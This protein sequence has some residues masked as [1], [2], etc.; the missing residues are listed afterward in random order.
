MLAVLLLL[1]FIV[2]DATAIPKGLI[3]L[4]NSSSCPK[5]YWTDATIANG[6]F[7]VGT[8]TSADIGTLFGA[9]L[10]DR[11]D[12]IHRHLLLSVIETALRGHKYRDTVISLTEDVWISGIV[13]PTTSGYPFLQLRM[14][15]HTKDTEG[16]EGLPNGTIAFFDETTTRCPRGWEVYEPLLGRTA[17]PT[18]QGDG[19]YQG[20][21]QEPPWAPT[22]ASNASNSSAIFDVEGHRHNVV[23]QFSS[24]QTGHV[25]EDL[26]NV[27][28]LSFPDSSH[29][30]KFLSRGPDA[31]LPFVRLLPCVQV[32]P[33]ARLYGI[34]IGM[35]M[36]HKA[37]GCDQ[38]DG[39][40]EYS[41]S[42]IPPS[43][44]HRLVVGT[45]SGTV[46]ATFGS[47]TLLLPTTVVMHN[48][49][50]WANSSARYQGTQ[51]LICG[52]GVVDD[53]LQPDLSFVA[54]P[55]S[56][57]FGVPY[58]V[59]VMCQYHRNNTA[60]NAH[61]A[62]RTVLPT[63]TASNFVTTSETG[64][65]T[66]TLTTSISPTLSSTEVGTRTAAL[67]FTVTSEMTA[68]HN[69]MEDPPIILRNSSTFIA[70]AGKSVIKP[71]AWRRNAYRLRMVVQCRQCADNAILLGSEVP[72]QQ[73][74]DEV[75]VTI[76]NATSNG[77]CLLLALEGPLTYILESFP[78]AGTKQPLAVTLYSTENTTFF[79]E[80]IMYFA[81]TYNRSVAILSL[82]EREV[83]GTNYTEVRGVWIANGTSQPTQE[84]VTSLANIGIIP[85][86]QAEARCQKKSN[87][88]MV[89][90]GLFVGL[91]LIAVLIGGGFAAYRY[92]WAQRQKVQ[93]QQA[94]NTEHPSDGSSHAA[95]GGAVGTSRSEPL[96]IEDGAGNGSF[97][98]R[99][100]IQCGEKAEDCASRKLE[101]DTTGV[102]GGA[103][104]GSYDGALEEMECLQSSQNP[105]NDLVLTKDEC[106]HPNQNPVEETASN[107][108]LEN[109]LDSR[110]VLEIS[111]VD[112]CADGPDS[113]ARPPAEEADEQGAANNCAAASPSSVAALSTAPASTGRAGTPTSSQSMK[114]HNSRR[115]STGAGAKAAPR[116]FNAVSAPHCDCFSTPDVVILTSLSKPAAKSAKD[117]TVRRAATM[118]RLR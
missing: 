117:A 53:F 1:L 35:M 78:F 84:S 3:A 39:D 79:M 63:S 106:T 114:H 58:D 31:H 20:V 46:G 57:S 19:M 45:S 109:P 60:T 81:H 40:E 80:K 82:E 38:I 85:R 12:R 54:T 96:A 6:R 70:V 65:L 62:S 112:V 88:T 66:A 41:I 116:P 11:E 95:F 107:I 113:G 67:S 24:F 50:S 102:E 26:S 29:R 94:A 86:S 72:V 105:T 93:Q 37:S 111:D 118:T 21:N 27:S 87:L 15:R 104:N 69:W 47:T 83:C 10:F 108:V 34:P 76:P 44:A 43:F 49:S 4:F 23:V 68:S 92:K 98:G 7:I 91:A 71:L 42:S 55:Q 64:T 5:G 18:N 51:D 56:A 52:N 74:A 30:L 32:A 36:F 115:Q 13:P 33:S 90:V 8:N 110:D 101:A 17:V 16:F 48:H 2:P 89:I 22:S 100:A 97:D 25:S 103:E 14:C 73:G 77:V 59:L 9:P 75:N 61:T 28:T 99:V